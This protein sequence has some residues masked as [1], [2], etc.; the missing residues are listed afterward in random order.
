MVAVISNDIVGPRSDTV[1]IIIAVI[2]INVAAEYSR[3]GLKCPFD[4]CLLSSDESSTKRDFRAELEGRVWITIGLPLDFVRII[5]SSC[6]PDR[7]VRAAGLLALPK[8]VR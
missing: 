6:Y 2:L 7:A 3:Y 4:H 1:C 8:F 5:A